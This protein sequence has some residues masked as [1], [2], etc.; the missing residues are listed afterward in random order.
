MIDPPS[1]VAVPLIVIEEF[2]SFSLAIDPA[3]IVFVTDPVSPVVTT[4][5]LTFGSVIVRSSVGFVTVR[6]VSWLSA[7]EPSKTMLES[8]SVSPVTT[9]EVSVLFV[10]VSVPAIVAKSAS[11][12]AVLNSASVPVRVFEARETDLF[13]SVCVFVVPTTAPVAPCA[14]VAPV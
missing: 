6:V 8:L 12:S 7:D 11:A 5:P 3:S 13:V 2:V 4:V 9:G 14:S 10:R 1:A